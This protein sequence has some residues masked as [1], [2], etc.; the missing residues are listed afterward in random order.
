MSKFVQKPG[1]TSE[2]F[3]KWVKRKAREIDHGIIFSM[4]QKSRDLEYGIISSGEFPIH[5]IIHVRLDLRH[6]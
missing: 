5:I 4:K 3:N 1:E 2:E 6:L